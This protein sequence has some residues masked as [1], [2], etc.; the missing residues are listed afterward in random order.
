M[1]VQTQNKTY[2]VL[3]LLLTYPSKTWVSTLDE[4]K[5][6]LSSEALLSGSHISSISQLIDCLQNN[7]LLSLEE[8]YVSLFDFKRLLSLYLFEHSY[9]DSRDRGQAMTDLIAQYDKHDLQLQPGELPDYL[10][11]FLEHLSYLPLQQ[12]VMRCP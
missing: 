11:V 10:P 5:T 4:C 3:G 7:D 6:V 1:T 9:G 8:S 2:K 12:A